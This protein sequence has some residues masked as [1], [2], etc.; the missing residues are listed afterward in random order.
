MYMWKKCI[1]TVIKVIISRAQH[2]W[3]GDQI[4]LNFQSARNATKIVPLR[5][6]RLP[7]S[8]GI[9]TFANGV[10]MEEISRSVRQAKQAKIWDV[11]C[12]C[13]YSLYVHVAGPYHHDDVAGGRRCAF[14]LVGGCPIGWWRVS[15]IANNVRTSGPTHW[16]H[17]SLYFY[18][19]W[20]CKIIWGVRGVRPPDL[21]HCQSLWNTPLADIPALV[22]CL[23]GG[24][25]CI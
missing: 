8:S 14:L 18:L 21:P 17:V 10:R 3:S 13:P 1:I 23:K 25:Y 4:L 7:D 19:N 12:T 11:D 24:K 15:F 6:S 22:P 20:L 5:P 2:Y 9:F 16:R